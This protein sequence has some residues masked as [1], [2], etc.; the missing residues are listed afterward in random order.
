LA[1]NDL[2]PVLAGAHAAPP[3]GSSPPAWWTALE[4]AAA[5]ERPRE[6]PPGTFV[7]GCVAL[8]EPL[9]RAAREELAGAVGEVLAHA[10][11]EVSDAVRPLIR[12]LRGELAALCLPVLQLELQAEQVSAALARPPRTNAA[13]GFVHELGHPGRLA[14]VLGEHPG[15]ARLLGARTRLAVAAGAELIE[16]LAADWDALRFTL[17]SGGGPGRLTDVRALG[18]SHDGGRRV[19]A[20]E[21]AGGARI[22]YKPRS[23]QVDAAWNGLLEW[24]SGEGGFAPGF[25]PL[26]LLVRDGYAWQEWALPAGCADRAAVDRYFRRLGAQLAVL[27][28]L[29]ATD[30]HQEN[31][32]AC[33]EHPQIVDL[34]TLF[35]PRLGASAADRL[36]PLIAETGLDCVLRVGLLP[37]V[38][39]LFGADI[40]GL[41]RDPAAHAAVEQDMWHAGPDGEPRF[42]ALR[43]ELGCG[44]NVVTVAGDPVRAH[45]HVEALA[46]GF[47]DAHALLERHA[48]E[49]LA[50]DGALS[51]FEGAQVRVVPRPTRVYA[52]L[53]GQLG[54]D[55][56]ALD[57]GLDAERV[58]NALWLHAE[59]RPEL[60]ALA[61]AEHHD[62]WRG[63]IP[64]LTTTPGSADGH[65]HVLG[66]L[67][68]LFTP[69]QASHPADVRRLDASDRAR[70]VAFLRQSVVGAAAGLKP[71]RRP[72]PAP[73]APAD[74]QRLRAAALGI[75]RRLALLALRDGGRAGWLAVQRVDGHP[76]GYL[77]VTR[78]GLMEGQAGIALF[79]AACAA[80][81]HD[82]RTESLARAALEQLLTV[83]NNEPGTPDW[84]ERGAVAWALHAAARALADAPLARRAQDLAARTEIEPAPPDTLEPDAALALAVVAAACGDDDMT[85][86]AARARPRALTVALAPETLAATAR[87]RATAALD[88]VSAA[89][90]DSLAHGT[91]GLVT[92]G[93]LL[94]ERAGDADVARR[95]AALAAGCLERAEREPLRCA[96][97][98]AV[99]LPGLERG[100]AGLGAAWLTLARLAAS[101]P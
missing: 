68:E 7:E 50:R 40:G 30:M 1:P 57:D 96:G 97:P 85:V 16:R 72:A 24:L 17:L 76:G 74:A 2:A 33:G 86:A 65:H 31:V 22:A 62:L 64:K 18:D 60:G 82:A 63:D 48:A 55:I 75:A 23:A 14:Q 34:E 11:E 87:A 95:A 44:E 35:Q 10:P 38:N 73:T 69:H 41:G 99:E 91:L 37:Q 5:A 53:L 3:A 81:T 100:L 42:G 36:D 88:A 93:A 89:A 92:T 77:R 8:V 59:S 39:P 56:A 67:E 12:I 90:D 58:L 15:L 79:L 32:V 84:D 98:G 61:P 9:A 80:A 19:L 43:M 25:K 45:E 52:V 4:R 27:Y 51:A 6:H 83:A 28:A 20:L 47:A 13:D 101:C 66:R 21:F 46:A 71:I 70:Q 54:A 29:R 78:T 94:A 26:E 49:L